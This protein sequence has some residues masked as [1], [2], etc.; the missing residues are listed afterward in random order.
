VTLIDVRLTVVKVLLGVA[1]VWLIC[2]VLTATDAIPND[3]DHWAYTTRT[4]TKSYVLDASPWF[5][6]PYPCWLLSVL[7]YR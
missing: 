4:D 5:Q 7:L 1:I 3:P 6:I 2:G